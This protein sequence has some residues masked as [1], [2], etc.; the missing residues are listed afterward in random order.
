MSPPSPTEWRSGGSPRYIVSVPL[1]TT[2]VSDCT[3]SLWRRPFAP[4]S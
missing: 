3:G 1:S 2:N 4:G